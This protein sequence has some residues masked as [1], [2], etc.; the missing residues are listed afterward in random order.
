[1][2]RDKMSVKKFTFDFPAF[3]ALPVVRRCYQA[4]VA[5][6]A[7]FILTIVFCREPFRGYLAEVQM[8]GPTAEGLD[9]AK[10]VDWIKQSDKRVAAIATGSGTARPQVRITLVAARPQLATERLDELAERFLFQYLPDRLQNYRHGALAELRSASQAARE[11]EDAARLALEALRQRQLAQVLKTAEA[12]E[13]KN[14]IAVENPP[15]N[16]VTNQNQVGGLVNPGMGPFR[17]RTGDASDGGSALAGALSE[18]RAKA[19]DKLHTLRLDLA[20]FMSNCTDEHPDVIRLRS[21]IQSLER[22]LGI[23][24]KQL[25]ASQAIR[26]VKQVWGEG[27]TGDNDARGN[28]PGFVSIEKNEASN[29]EDADQAAAILLELAK[30]SRERQAAEQQLSERMQELTSQPGASQ[31]SAAP[32][33]LVTRM[34]GTPR[35]PTVALGVLFAGAI[36]IVVF[37]YSQN[38]GCGPT[39]DSAGV[40]ASTLELPVVG[41][42]LGMRETARQWRL[43]LLTTARLRWILIGSEAVVGLAVAACL[44]SVAMEPSLARQVLADP[45]GTLSEVMGRWG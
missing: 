35:T 29:Q 45:F 2:G 21:Q 17:P 34:G 28:G 9:L 40:L 25:E 22:E 7:V 12:A 33:H 44:I 14:A 13:R 27:A 31:W 36:G 24:A 15:A 30:A 6:L 16:D 19:L 38:D 42:L 18:S 1:M 4:T 23:E 8:T 20:G 11:H 5:A 32:A 37:R 43:R 10:A 39:I 3:C 26:T 41:N